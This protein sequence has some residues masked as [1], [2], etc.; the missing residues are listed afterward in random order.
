[1]IAPKII[2]TDDITD[3]DTPQIATYFIDTTS[4]AQYRGTGA[5]SPVK[6]FDENNLQPIQGN[7]SKKTATYSLLTTD[8]IIECDGTFD[9][10]LFIQDGQAYGQIFYIK[11]IG[12]GTITLDCAGPDLID[13]AATYALTAGQ[14]VCIAGNSTINGWIILS[15]FG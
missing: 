8:F 14:S 4:G 1:M 11:N 2:L 9:V 13:G 12:S 15:K 7:L 5:A 6:M 3:V 10:D